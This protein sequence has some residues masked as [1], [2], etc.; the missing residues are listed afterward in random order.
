MPHRPPAADAASGAL[1]TASRE[2]SGLTR[3]P[4]RS[5]IFL[6]DIDMTLL[7][8]AGAGRTAFD[9]AFFDVL[10]V[11]GA[12]EGYHFFGGVDLG[13][14]GDVYARIER[15]PVPAAVLA[16]I[17][18]RY[19]AHLVSEIAG[20]AGFRAMP[21]AR[22]L[23]ARLAGSPG[24]HLGIATGNFEEGAWRKL[25][26]VGLARF[27]ATGGFGSDA[28]DRAEMTRVAIE[29]VREHAAAHGGPGIAPDAGCFV[30]GDSP[31]DVE[32]AQACGARAIAVA[33]GHASREELE[34]MGPYLAVDDLPELLDR[35]PA[36]LGDEP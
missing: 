32:A 35:L 1:A 29:R 4:G 36:L 21:G 2:T 31:R 8:S 18:E 15:S 33:T 22:R 23:L 3:L 30:V 27:F 10:G 34:A 16:R 5:C 6:F 17:R 20:S 7:D 14:V 13:I 26:A 19:L 25:Q 12:F 11:E 9:R 24:C 28:A